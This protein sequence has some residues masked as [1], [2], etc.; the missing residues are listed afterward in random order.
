MLAAR[1]PFAAASGIL[2]S[3]ALFMAL[4]QLVGVP[5]AP[6]EIVEHMRIEFTPQIREMPVEIK[7]TQKPERKPP[8][9]T[10][11]TPRAGIDRG[12]G[13]ATLVRA[14][15]I[16][17]APP[18]R[19][20]LPMGVDRDVT[21]LVRINPDYPPRAQA[22]GIEGWVRVQFTVTETGTVRDA[23]V[24]AAEPRNVFDAA[25]L[26][27]IARWRYNPRVEGGEALERVGLQAL[28]KFE[29]TSN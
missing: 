4:S 14:T 11:T 12:T 24:V 27:A 28:L 7:R 2:A 18:P 22:Q 3:L 26:E 5:M 23:I 16:G 17:V 13:P 19:K 25:A 29:L 20:G 10:P 8:P 1:I 21:P 15:R 6:I 9:V